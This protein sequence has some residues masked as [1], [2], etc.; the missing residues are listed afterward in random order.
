MFAAKG[1]TCVDEDTRYLRQRI[2][3]GVGE[4]GQALFFATEVLCEGEG[5]ALQTAAAYLEAAGFRVAGRRAP[6]HPGFWPA[7]WQQQAEAEPH[8]KPL[9]IAAPACRQRGFLGQLPCVCPDGVDFW[10]VMGCFSGAPGFL[11]ARGRHHKPFLEAQLE[12]GG[13]L[14]EEAP[15]LTHGLVA[16]WAA[17]AF[18]RLAL[19]LLPEAGGGSLGPRGEATLWEAGDRF[20]F[21]MISSLGSG[22]A[23]VTHWGALPSRNPRPPRPHVKLKPVCKSKTSL[24]KVPGS[25]EALECLLRCMEEA[26]PHEACGA[27]FMSPSGEWRWRPTDNVAGR[28]GHAFAAGEGWLGLLREEEE[29]QSTL[30]CWVHSHPGG[31]ANL[32]RVDIQNLAPGG[33]QLWPGIM[34]MV[35]STAKEGWRELAWFQPGK[36]GF[37]CVGR[38]SRACFEARKK[39]AVKL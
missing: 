20:H 1:P 30:A 14:L 5:P 39:E 27:L 22:S 12:G 2:L 29:R 18:E 16:T 6:F 38:I 24:E 8:D 23:Q 19:G 17:L 21:D 15:G 28:P 36:K 37:A 11:F 13:T 7:T 34:Q 32:S 25:G 10:V 35:V 33:R 3:E 26:W 9:A 4:A 31:E